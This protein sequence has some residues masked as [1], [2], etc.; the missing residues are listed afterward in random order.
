[1]FSATFPEEIQRMAGKYLHNYIFV[2]VGV[3]GGACT[4]VEQTFHQVNKFDKRGK[5]LETLKEYGKIVI[6]HQS[7]SGY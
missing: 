3:V 1:M 5:L 2:A 7:F 4:D 6:L